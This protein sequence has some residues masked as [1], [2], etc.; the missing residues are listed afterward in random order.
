M[1]E[2]DCQDR[3]STPPPDERGATLA[4]IAVAM[5]AVLGSLAL[6]VDLAM[7][8]TAHGEAQRVADAAALAGASVFM[9]NEISDPEGAATRRAQAGLTGR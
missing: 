2:P 1:R 8:R 7:A 6:A 3:S 9:E 5:V 4:F